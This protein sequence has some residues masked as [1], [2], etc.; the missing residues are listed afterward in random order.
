MV[1]FV[2]KR[3]QASRRPLSVKL[4]VT[5]VGAICLGVAF[6]MIAPTYAASVSP[7]SQQMKQ[8]AAGKGAGFLC[9]NGDLKVCIRADR[10][11]GLVVSK[12]T[13][14]KSTSQPALVPDCP[15]SVTIKLFDNSGQIADT[16]VGKGCGTFNGPTTSIQA[17]DTYVAQVVA[18]FSAA[19]GD[20]GAVPSPDLN[21]P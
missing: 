13:V 4:I 16:L 6:L 19:A 7:A 8:S 3:S 5:L 1:P 12:V 11:K 15:F 10:N 18:C 17:G 20:C 14:R 21:I 2:K 9:T